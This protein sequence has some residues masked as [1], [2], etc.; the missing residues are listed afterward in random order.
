MRYYSDAPPD[1]ETLRIIA[2]RGDTVEYID[3]PTAPVAPVAPRYEDYVDYS[4]LPDCGYDGDCIVNQR[5]PALAQMQQ[6]FYD[7]AAH[8]ENVDL[9]AYAQA[10]SGGGAPYAP[11][12]TPAAQQTPPA[13]TAP[14]APSTT[15]GT[16]TTPATQGTQQPAGSSGLNLNAVPWYIWAAGAAAVWFLLGGRR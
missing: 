10:T 2:A 6:A 3:R 8:Y 1:A 12:A 15:P 14:A 9:Q 5:L 7:A 11:A 13:S 16:Q 4:K